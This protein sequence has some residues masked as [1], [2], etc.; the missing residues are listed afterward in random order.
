M[1]STCFCGCGAR[2]PFGRRRLANAAG[3]R[4]D[5]DLA[6]FGGALER[7]D[8]GEHAGELRELVAL[9]TPLRDTLRGIVHGTVDRR[10][11]DKAAA[12]AWLRRAHDAR[13]RLGRDVAEADFAGWDAMAQA[14]LL[15]AGRRAPAVVL[16]V[17]DTGMTVNND[18]RVRVRLRVE[19]EG[20][21]PFEVERKL[22]VSRLA[23]PRP[24]ERL[25]AAYDPAD[26]EKLTF[27]IA[28]LT[29]DG[30]PADRLAQLERLARL[31]REGALT[32]DE[33]AAEKARVLAGG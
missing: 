9:G 6:M 31:H 25:E 4:M 13:G 33:F 12:R 7:S 2:V 28:E 16:D 24:G 17:Q 30:P 15:Y 26:R 14:E 5:R 18:P 22:L 8:Q 19:P 10:Q 11:Y 1:A 3:E 27:R 23:I 20:E 32:D 21:P 29:D